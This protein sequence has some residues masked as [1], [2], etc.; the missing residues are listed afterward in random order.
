MLR[1]GLIENLWRLA[2]Q[3]LSW[4]NERHE[5]RSWVSN[6]QNAL[7]R[8]PAQGPLPTHRRAPLKWPDSFIAHLFDLLREHEL[9]H[10]LVEWL[11][12]V[13]A[14]RGDTVAEV[15]RRE[16]RRQAANQVSIGN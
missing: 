16:Q 9:S 13:L 12:N 11:E 5:A 2:G 1:L 10:T 15:L 14:E 6:L 7:Q 8:E 4:R 3:I